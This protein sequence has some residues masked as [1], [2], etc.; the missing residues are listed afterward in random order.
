MPRK[1]KEPRPAAAL[2]S[3]DE[4]LEFVRGANGKVGK[5]E[6]A[7]AFWVKGGDRPALKK[8]LAEMT[9]EGLLS[10]NRKS[11]KERGQLPPVAVLGDRGARR[12]RRTDSRAG[13][14][15][16]RRGRATARARVAARA[17]RG[18]AASRRSDRVTASWRA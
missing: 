18:A 12:R 4:I 7:R 11:F 8:M 1:R 3:K 10:G 14:L 6:I 15:G 2:P 9:D 17:A 13:G 16:P 5:R